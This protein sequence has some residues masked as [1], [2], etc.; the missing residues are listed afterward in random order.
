VTRTGW[1]VVCVLSI[2]DGLAQ[3]FGAY[4]CKQAAVDVAAIALLYGAAW[5]V[6]LGMAAA[7][8]GEWIP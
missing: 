2:L 6:V 4:Y 5:C 7:A 1:R 8:A 3:G